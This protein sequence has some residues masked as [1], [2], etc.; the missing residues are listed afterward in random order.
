MRTP[1]IY[2]DD[3]SKVD[4]I[5][6]KQTRG[7]AGYVPD[8]ID[9]ANRTVEVVA[10]T[11]TKSKIF[12]PVR[13]ELID[14]VL[15]MKGFVPPPDDKVPL[16]IEHERHA[17]AVI[18]SFINIRTSGKRLVG[19]VQFASSE[20][21]EPYWIKVKE[22]HLDRFSITY[23]ALDRDSVYIAEN[24]TAEVEGRKYKGPLLVTKSWTVKALGLVIYA[25]DSKAKARSE[26]ENITKG[27]TMDKRLFQYLVRCGMDENATE[28][29]AW[30]FFAGLDANRNQPGP[31]NNQPDPDNQP[32]PVTL[33]ED[34]IRSEAAEAE[35]TR[36]AGINSMCTKFEVPDALREDMVSKGLTI[37][38]ARERVMDF[39]EKSR[40]DNDQVG[41]RTVVVEDERDKFR[42]AAE[43]ALLIRCGED[44]AP[45]TPAVG[46]DD[47]T[48]YTLRELARHALQLANQSQKG[49]PFQMIGRALTTSDLPYIMANVANKALFRGWDTAEETWSTWVGTGSVGDFKTN[50]SPRISESDDLEEV[51]EHG[52]YQYG[53]RAEAQESYTIATYGKIFAVTRQAIIND[54]LR[55]LST[56]PR[57][58][59]EAAARKV[60]DVVY[61]VLTANAAMGDG[62]A[63]FAS[64]HSNLQTSGAVPGVAQIAAGILAM[65]TQTDIKGLR[66]LNI[67]PRFFIAPKALEGT[68]EVFFKSNRFADEGT[69]GT[70]DDATAT[71][72]VN[73]YSGEYFSRIYEPRLDDDSTTAWYLAANKGRT[74]V[75]FFLNGQQRPYTES[76]DGWTVDGVEYKVRIDCGAKAMDWRG[77]YKDPGA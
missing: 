42:A 66:R 37:D 13:Y 30:A 54:D 38:R 67:R 70:P 44:F 49:N 9:E 16:T 40:T 71:T 74:V 59:G 58:H 52:E 3:R 27:D 65:G 26:S 43:D 25:A 55:A 19:R 7:K 29:E 64:G 53:T 56:I 41:H 39:I 76:K 60:G 21:A 14:E 6:R 62:T 22:G 15:L 77:L 1:Y 28:A 35:R 45:E 10:A 73:P 5:V 72:R 75:A 20:D 63:L 24:E 57:S 36:I 32:D 50:Y 51:P 34:A 8:T 48:G 33:D 17:A 18:G 2:R 12:D 23:P 4:F 11:E 31:N 47:L 68:G 61:A 69:P 46:A